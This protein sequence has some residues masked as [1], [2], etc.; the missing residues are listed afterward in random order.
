MVN[1]ALAGRGLAAASVCSLLGLGA[2]VAPSAAQDPTPGPGEVV[3]TFECPDGSQPSGVVPENATQAE[4][5]E[6]MRAACPD[7]EFDEPP[8]PVPAQKGPRVKVHT[9]SL[10]TQDLDDLRANRFFI[11]VSCSRACTVKSSVEATVLDP[12]ALPVG[13]SAARELKA[14]RMTRIPIRF[15]AA[16][17]RIFRKASRV[18]VNGI[19]TATDAKARTTSYT[20]YR[21]CRLAQ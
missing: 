10:L 13:R 7:S 12:R 8:P 1:R 15:R 11:K 14:D 18:R 6:A 9:R 21:T 2:M 3:T 17:R 20:W 4:L 16:D 19:V 5:E